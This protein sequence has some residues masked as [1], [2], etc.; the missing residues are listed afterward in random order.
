MSE[1]VIVF[2]SK[3]GE[4]EAIPNNGLRVVR[5]YDYYFYGKKRSRFTLAE[6][7]SFDARVTIQESGE[8]GSTNSIPIKFFESFD[9]A[10]KAEHELMNLVKSDPQSLQL[11]RVL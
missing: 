9:S 5:E 7:K 4:F 6:V 8:G 1:P 11:I 2:S 10:Q 3:I